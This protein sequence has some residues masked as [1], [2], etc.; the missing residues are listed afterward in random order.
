VKYTL[1][2]EARR[3]LREAAQYYRD[4]AGLSRSQ[5]LLRE[6]KRGVEL[7]LRYPGLGGIWLCGKRRLLLRRFPYSI[8]YTIEGDVVLILAVAHHSRESGYWQG[9]E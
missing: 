9:R 5:A 2:P 6:F 3:D 7:L 4:Q 8:I 1:H